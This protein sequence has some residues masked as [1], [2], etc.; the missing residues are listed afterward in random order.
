MLSNKVMLICGLFLYHALSLAQS[1]DMGTPA[2]HN[3]S[4]KIY[5]GH[6][7]NWSAVQDRRGVMYFGNTNGIVEY[8]GARWR[9][10]T[11]PSKTISRSLAISPSGTI[12]YGSVGDLG[13]LA[14]DEDGRVKLTSLRDKIPDNERQFNDVWQ[15]FCLGD[16][17][18]FLTREKI[19][20]YFQGRF[21]VLPG[22]FATSQSLVFQEH[23]FYVDADHGLSVIQGDQIRPLRALNWLSNGTRL[24]FAPYGEHEILAIRAS[25]DAFILKLGSLW[26]ADTRSYQDK[27]VE[28]K[29]IA[30]VFASPVAE[31]A[32]L[33]QAY[34]YRLYAIRGNH[35]E[36]LFALATLRGGVVIFNAQGQVL[37][38]L[39][40][41]VGLIDN[42]VTSLYQDQ[43]NHLW[44]TSN[45]GLAYV[46]QG[47][48]ASY[49]SNAHGIDGNVLTSIRHQGELYVGSFQ[50][51]LV[52]EAF[53]FSFETPLQKFVPVTYGLGNIWEFIEYQGEL[54]ASGAMGLFRIRNHSATLIANSPINGYCLSAV[55]KWPQHLLMGVTGGLALFK[56]SA[57]SWDFV[58]KI[59][60]IHD[61][62]R[63]IAQDAEGNLWLSTEVNGLYY[64]QMSTTPSLQ[65]PLQ[66]LGV[67]E[68]LPTLE[69]TQA[70]VFGEQVYV[71]TPQGLYS[72]KISNIKQ[73]PVRF[74]LDQEVGASINRTPA[75]INSIARDA[76]NDS[77]AYILSTDTET[78][79]LVPDQHGKYQAHPTNFDGVAPPDMPINPVNAS[80]YWLPGEQLVRITPLPKQVEPRDFKILIRHISTKNKRVLLD[81]AFSA[82]AKDTSAASLFIETQDK[83]NLPKLDF[84]E[85]GLSFAFA[86]P[87]FANP[88]ALTYRYQL[89][90]FEQEW[91]D[92]STDSSKEYSYIPHGS[93]QF[94]V[95]AKN[96]L[97]QLSKV[98]M[99]H[100]H[101]KRPWY[102]T[103]WAIMIAV[104]L[105]M[106][107]IA[108]M[109]QL[110]AK[111]LIKEKQA[112]EELVQQRTQELR[113]ASLTDPLTGLR[114]RRFLKEVLNTDI[115][116]FIKYKNFILD[117]KNKRSNTSDKEVFGIYLLDMDHFKQVNDQYGHE[118]GDS[119]L[120][121]FAAILKA[122][123]RE[124]DVVVRLGGEEFLVVLKKTQ[125]DYLHEFAQRLL[126]KV[127]D[128]EFQLEHGVRL[129]KTCSIGYVAYPFDQDQPNLLSFEQMITLA[130]MAMYHAKQGGRN[131]AMYLSRGEQWSGAQN[132]VEQI[133][134]SLDFALAN[135]Y[136]SIA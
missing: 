41:S 17:V 121:E 106:L 126:K 38:T 10:I 112:L 119:V 30:E 124:D 62:I 23:L 54:L 56:K 104:M 50:Q 69:N 109:I 82:T 52:Q 36:K 27:G 12:F 8:D 76:S 86:A 66:H 116:A 61:N 7:Q 14:A 88:E 58:G 35:Q 84:D 80:E 130:D 111:K 67:K 123:V 78:L 110:Q 32:K 37:R 15:V 85:N 44:I 74:Q 70:F 92:W 98:A 1:L 115:S 122:S 114:N 118:S 72:L 68:G 55:N 87:Y 105:G 135:S 53:H 131:R 25:G 83:L 5:K 6:S 75:M 29:Y 107:A 77:N 24:S 39:N 42:T 64:A 91:S 46:E 73:N 19:F 43:H 48:A 133:M 103:W 65:I 31:F 40:K 47:S 96:S 113:E 45:S 95:Q 20:R 134:T 49:F 89:V 97:G 100:F 128:T 2:I 108:A 93:Y 129:H 51:L 102:L 125:A 71:I 57:D 59:A 22:K 21:S 18:Y 81:G 90:G 3:Y 120:K 13:Y 136:L 9:L 63:R 94:Q 33:A 101:I 4:A 60:G 28:R 16:S 11:T 132:H 117:G 26:D 127:A 79:W 34:S 99:Y